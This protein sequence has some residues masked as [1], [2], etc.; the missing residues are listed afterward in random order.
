MRSNGQN[1]IEE[2]GKTLKREGQTRLS[3]RERCFGMKE[4][5]FVC[6]SLAPLNSI[7]GIISYP[8]TKMS[9][10][11]LRIQIKES[12]LGWTTYGLRTNVTG[13]QLLRLDHKTTI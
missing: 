6:S 7:G 9:L 13:L 5:G 2:R 8:F 10:L 4:I 11:L 1:G 12:C 3:S